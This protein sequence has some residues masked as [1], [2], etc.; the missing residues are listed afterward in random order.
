MADVKNVTENG[1]SGNEDLK[2]ATAEI[3]NYTANIVSADEETAYDLVEKLF[4]AL[5]RLAVNSIRTRCASGMGELEIIYNDVNTE[6]DSN[7]DF[8]SEVLKFFCYLLKIIFQ[9]QYSPIF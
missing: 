5:Q 1:V 7:G 4:A 3:N 8:V 6:F 2:H 9:M